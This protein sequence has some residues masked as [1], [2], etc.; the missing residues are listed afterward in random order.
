MTIIQKSIA[1]QGV[2]SLQPQHLLLPL[3]QTKPPP[4]PNI[5][6]GKN[7]AVRKVANIAEYVRSKTARANTAL[8]DG[9]IILDGK[10]WD[11]DEYNREYPEPVLKYRVEQIDGRQVE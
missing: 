10:V 5:S 2:Q 6:K 9:K 7:E 1:L 4:M 11:L 8:I 3:Y